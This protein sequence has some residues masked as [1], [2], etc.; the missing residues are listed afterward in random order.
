MWDSTCFLSQHGHK[1]SRKS[2]EW[3]ITPL[4]YIS[5][6]TLNNSPPHTSTN[7]NNDSGPSPDRSH[8]EHPLRGWHHHALASSTNDS[9]RKSDSHHHLEILTMMNWLNHKHQTITSAQS[10]CWTLL[11]YIHKY[12][13]S[14]HYTTLTVVTLERVTSERS[15]LARVSEQHHSQNL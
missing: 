1:W 2:L 6:P 7:N 5:K 10:D 15:E 12:D 8:S 14:R 4:L 9:V 3:R 11:L 13:Q